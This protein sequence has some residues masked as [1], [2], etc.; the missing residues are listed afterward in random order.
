MA[1]ELKST[2]LC[3]RSRSSRAETA[4]AARLVNPAVL[5]LGGGSVLRRSLGVGR[6]FQASDLVAVEINRHAPRIDVPRS[7]LLE[8]V[9]IIPTF[10][11]EAVGHHGRAQQIT[12]LTA[13]HSLFD[14][15]DRSL[16][17][18][19]ALL[20]IDAVHA[21]AGHQCDRRRHNKATNYFHESG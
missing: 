3:S 12:D 1:I 4:P 19:I 5:D 21:A 20:N 10:L 7:A 17:E 14:G 6:L 16:I 15:I 13:R 9:N 11:V 18:E 8:I 2:G